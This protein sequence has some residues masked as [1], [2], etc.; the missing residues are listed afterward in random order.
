MHTIEQHFFL[1]TRA[2]SRCV[3]VRGKGIHVQPVNNLL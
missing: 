1:L 2:V 3:Y